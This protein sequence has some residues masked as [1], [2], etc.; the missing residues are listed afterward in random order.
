MT[1]MA[2]NIEHPDELRKL[3]NDS[4][5]GSVVNVGAMTV[6]RG[7]LRPGWRWSNDVRPTAGTASCEFEH[8]GIVLDGRLHVEMDDGTSRDLG[9]GD[10]YI[11][12]P[13]HD[14]WVVGDEPYH[15]IDWASGNKEFGKPAA[16]SGVNDDNTN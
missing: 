9:P 7:E 15:S 14:A 16:G 2:K 5:E 13:G 6:I 1:V 4:G 10:V 8:T 3:P 11:I 12:P